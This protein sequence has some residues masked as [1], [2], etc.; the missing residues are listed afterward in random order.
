MAYLCDICE[1]RPVAGGS[2][3][4]HRGIAG[5]QWKRRAHH[6][7]RTVRPNTH[8]VTLFIDGVRTAVRACANCIKRVKFDNRK[9][10]VLPVASI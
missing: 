3:K 2:H 1:K 10:V 7:L 4:H 8:N 6:T 9:A 5:G